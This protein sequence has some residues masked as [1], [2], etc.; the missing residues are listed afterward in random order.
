MMPAR[1][2]MVMKR[3]RKSSAEMSID[4]IG[5]AQLSARHT[6]YHQSAHHHYHHHPPYPHPPPHPPPP[7]TWQEHFVSSSFSLKTP[8]EF[9][10]V[11]LAVLGVIA[12][13]ADVFLRK[14]ATDIPSLVSTIYNEGRYGEYV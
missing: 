8:K 3:S 7:G 9:Q 6:S 11:R 4:C 2:A 14:I 12:A 10:G 5:L 1:A 13:I